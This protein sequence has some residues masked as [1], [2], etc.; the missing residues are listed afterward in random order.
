MG[1]DYYKGQK[2]EKLKK[3]LLKSG[4]LFT[5]PEF[6]PNQKS[7]F[8]SRTETEVIWKRPTVRSYAC[9]KYSNRGMLYD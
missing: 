8:Y 5:D 4:Q 9:L 2:Y 6:L 3:E 7:L 1:V